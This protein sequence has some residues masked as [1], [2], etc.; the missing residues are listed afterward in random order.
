MAILTNVTE[1]IGS[2]NFMFYGYAMTASLGIEVYDQ[3]VIFSLLDVCRYC[4]STGKIKKIEN[5]H[6]GLKLYAARQY[7]RPGLFAYSLQWYIDNKGNFENPIIIDNVL[8]DSVIM[9]VGSEKDLAVF[10]LKND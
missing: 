5:L 8:E 3:Y 9:I 2:K 1:I 6:D 7:P 4:P 10:K